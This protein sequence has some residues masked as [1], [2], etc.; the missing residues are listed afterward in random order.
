AEVGADVVRFLFLARKADTHLEFDLELAKKQSMENPVYYVQY[1]HARI[2]NIVRKAQN[3]GVAEIAPQD[4]AFQR[5]TQEDELTII[6]RLAEFPDL[7]S[8]AGGAL[9]RSPH[10]FHCLCT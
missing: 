3:E 1:A 10:T 7:V 8:E 5:L 9:R 4:V 2:A 6:R